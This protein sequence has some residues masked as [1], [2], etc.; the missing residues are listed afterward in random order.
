MALQRCTNSLSF[1]L[2]IWISGLVT[3]HPLSLACTSAPCCSRYSTTVTRLYPAAKCRGVDCLPSTSLQFTFWRVQSFYMER[4]RTMSALTWE[5]GI[6]NFIMIP[7]LHGRKNITL[8]G[9]FLVLTF[10]TSRS[11]DLEAS[12]SCL[13][14]SK[15]PVHAPSRNQKIFSI[16][17]S[18][19][20]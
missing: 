19:T 6:I 17:A 7:Q 14:V 12:N 15:L 8:F 10:T 16:T 4:W 1:W 20:L 13:S 2:Y 9:V 3:S 5:S 18:M 11:P